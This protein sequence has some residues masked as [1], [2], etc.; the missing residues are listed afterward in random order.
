MGNDGDIKPGNEPTSDLPPALRGRG[1][2]VPETIGGFRIRR[3]IASGGMGLVYEAVQESPHRSVA[4]K[5]MRRTAA[6]PS[7]L[8]RF[9]NEAQLMARL[10]HPGIA[11]VYEAGVDESGSEPVPFIAFEFINCVL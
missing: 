6:T 4:L 5:V 3:M 9:R 10:H 11:Q 8:K 7:S 2:R 1:E